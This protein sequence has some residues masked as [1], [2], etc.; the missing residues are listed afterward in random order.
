LNPH[1]A[2]RSVSVSII[3]TS[4]YPAVCLI[5]EN[6]VVDDPERPMKVQGV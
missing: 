6:H 1:Q 4:Y 2:S 3:G 5:A